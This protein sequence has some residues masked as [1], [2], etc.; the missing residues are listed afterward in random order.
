MNH[1][2]EN[3]HRRSI[4]LPGYDYAKSGAYFITI[5][6]QNHACLFGNIV[7][8]EMVLT[9]TG[10]IVGHEWMRTGEI[11]DGITLDTWAVMPNHFHAIVCIADDDRGTARRAP[12]EQF[13]KPIAG[14][15][16]TIVRSFK[17]AVTKQIH[18]IHQSRTN[19]IWQ[20]NYYEHVIRHDDELTRIREYIL[21]NPVRWAEDRYFMP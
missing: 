1:D 12:T 6:T 15:I 3:H 7:N 10:Q 19:V 13:G 4:R 2:S 21:T 5:C 14:S 8:G 17:S 11:R 18:E 16:P 20:K 9:R